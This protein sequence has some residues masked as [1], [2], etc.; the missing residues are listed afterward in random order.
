MELRHLR[1]FL[2]VAESG[3]IGV[4][5]RRLHISP[6]AIS[7]TIRD[8]EDE[9]GV[10]LFERKNRRILLS[11]AGTCFLQDARATL[12]LAEKSVDNVRRFSRGESGT[13]TIGFFAG[14]FGSF[15]PKL[16]HRFRRRFK[17]V[18][19]SLIE[20]VPSLQMKALQDGVIDIG[21]T[22]PFSGPYAL[23]LRSEHFQ[24]ERLYVVLPRKHR[25]A[26]RKEVHIKELANDIFVLNDRKYSPAIFDRIIELCARARFSPTIAATSSVASGVVALV[27]AGEGIAILSEAA[28]T[29]SSSLS[30]VPISDSSA[31]IDI[32]VAWSPQRET[33]VLRSFLAHIRSSKR[34][35]H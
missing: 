13:L 30:F 26:Q 3:G 27:E 29:L 24:T 32:V 31:K 20:M 19:I 25:L 1:Y 7:E 10:S 2:S 16:I 17:D 6:S 18:K 11:D 8:L 14:G 22:R 21:F 12:A 4:S 33:P 28:R 15:A 5:A 9:L 23:A 34:A 35:K